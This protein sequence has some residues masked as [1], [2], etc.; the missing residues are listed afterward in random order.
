MKK[1]QKFYEKKPDITLFLRIIFAIILF[2][3]ISFLTNLIYRND[4]VKLSNWIVEYEGVERTVEAP[5]SKKIEKS[6]VYTFT[7]SFFVK[8]PKESVLV[9]PRM[10]GYSFQVRLNGELITTVGDMENPTANIWNY[11]HVVPLKEEIPVNTLQSLEVKVY[12]LHDIGFVITPYMTT[13]Q[14][15]NISATIQNLY[16]NGLNY[17][18]SGMMFFVGIILFVLWYKR[19]ESSQVYIYFTVAALFFCIYNFDYTYRLSTGSLEVYLTTRKVIFLS[20]ILSILFIIKGVY[21]LIK[22]KKLPRWVAFISL[23]I[24]MPVVLA[25]DFVVLAKA[26]SMAAVVIFGSLIGVLILID[27]ETKKRL[28]FTLA[29]LT[30]CIV[31]TFIVVFLNLTSFIYFNFAVFAIMLGFSFLIVN[32]FI[33]IEQEKSTLDSLSKTDKLT[34]AFNR[35]YLNQIR[36]GKTDI[37]VFIDVDNFKQLNDTMGHEK[38]DEVLKEIVKYTKKIIRTDD[39]I[40]RYGGDEF[41]IIFRKSNPNVTKRVMEDI[42]Y[43]IKEKFQIIGISY[44]VS[45]GE[46]DI[47]EAL[48]NADKNMY[49]MKKIRKEGAIR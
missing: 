14:K 4:G 29:F 12:G 43:Y 2:L 25:P 36:L 11:T 40:M 9:I 39:I 48:R 27:R 23:G 37:L 35:H 19:K 21:L 30:L 26:I 16:K 31:S 6:G 1:R 22:Q 44:G 8:N 45:Y 42:H 5:F 3:A 18:I 47:K 49:I 7:T 10:N 15:A 32:D 41:I 24:S 33:Q 13:L 20:L 38:G 17:I 28:A 34:G 46:K